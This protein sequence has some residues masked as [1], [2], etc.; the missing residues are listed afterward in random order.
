MTKRKGRPSPG[1][2]S[3]DATLRSQTGRGFYEHMAE[4]VS[5]PANIVASPDWVGLAAQIGEMTGVVVSAQR[6]RRWARG[7]RGEGNT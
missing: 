7:R 3:L 6:L 1:R 5:D 4:L 2:E